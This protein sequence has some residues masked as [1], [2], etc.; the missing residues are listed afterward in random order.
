MKVISA[1]EN[2]SPATGSA[3]LDVLTGA[4]SLVGQLCPLCGKGTIIKGK[5][6]YGCS[7]WRNGCTYRKAFE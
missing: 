4:D 6:A 7:E 1:T 5:T 2:A 3:Q